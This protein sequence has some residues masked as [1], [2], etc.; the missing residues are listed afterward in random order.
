[1]A[2]DM[3][4]YVE[5]LCSLAT[6]EVSVCKLSLGSGFLDVCCEV[7]DSLKKPAPIRDPL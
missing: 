1:M 2:T 6:E 7:V 5:A 3:T 4:G